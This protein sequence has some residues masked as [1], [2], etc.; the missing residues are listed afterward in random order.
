VV[1]LL[2]LCLVGGVWWAGTREHDFLTPPAGIQTAETSEK[3]GTA[4]PSADEPPIAIEAPPPPEPQEN[5]PELAN[6]RDEAVKDPA[7]LVEKARQLET[8]KKFQQSLLAWERILDSAPP[9]ETRTAEAIQAIQRLRPTLPPWNTEPTL[10][11]SITL[12]AGTGK[13]SA[14][15]LT[16]ILDEISRDL[17]Q[18]S[19]GILK[20]TPIVTA[21]NSIPETRGPAPIALWFAGPGA[22][23]PSTE[24][25]VF[26][27]RQADTLRD[28]VLKALLRVIRSHIARTASLTVPE[29]GIAGENPLDSIHSRITRLGWMELGSRLNKTLE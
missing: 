10:T 3:T 27:T 9:D 20:I 4:L 16:P 24:A 14:G 8:R 7:A 15:I 28:D 21:G 17:E 26:T 13:D 29:A 5:P 12:Q 11:I 22:G 2:C 25:L 23:A 1:I 18:A 19:S 6:Y